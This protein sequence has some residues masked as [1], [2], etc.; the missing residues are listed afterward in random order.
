MWQFNMFFFCVQC[1]GIGIVRG[2]SSRW[3]TEIMAWLYRGEESGKIPLPSFLQCKQGSYRSWETW[4]VMEFIISISRPGKSWNFSE[5][6]GKCW[7]FWIGCHCLVWNV[8]RQVK[9]VTWQWIVCQLS[10]WLRSFEPVLVKVVFYWL[11]SW[12]PRRKERTLSK[13][14]ASP[15]KV[16]AFNEFRGKS[17]TMRNLA[18][19]LNLLR[20]AMV[21][22]PL[23]LNLKDLRHS[24][25]FV[26]CVN[27]RHH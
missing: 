8:G 4:K 26:I 16:C 14:V 19:V 7:Q 20:C 9:V 25:R 2:R 15:E 13:T 5:G 6:F 24:L 1:L 11:F 18:C 23:M 21:N 17:G 12:I 27:L 3:S 22:V 10:D